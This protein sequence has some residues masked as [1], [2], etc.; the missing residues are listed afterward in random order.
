MVGL[1]SAGESQAPLRRGLQPAT[2]PRCLARART[3]H[4]FLPRSSASSE[5]STA[6]SHLLSLSFPFAL[7]CC[8]GVSLAIEKRA[9]Y[10]CTTAP[11]LPLPPLP[12]AATAGSPE[13]SQ[14]PA[15]R[16]PPVVHWNCPGLLPPRPKHLHCG[17]FIWGPSP[18]QSTLGRGSED[19][20]AP[21]NGDSC[22]ISLFTF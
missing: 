20:E 2:V 7:L 14:G 16:H 22:L 19:A 1:S 8:C 18:A 4:A 17:G 21:C 10:C 13:R 6:P 9:L 3:R 15:A 12:L 11:F 5:H